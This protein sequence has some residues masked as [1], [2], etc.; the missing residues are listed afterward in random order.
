MLVMLGLYSGV[1]ALLLHSLVDFNFANPSLAS[2][3]F[4]TAGLFVSYGWS[5]APVWASLMKRGLVAVG[6]LLV[7]AGAGGAAMQLGWADRVA[8]VNGLTQRLQASQV[9]LDLA[10][11]GPRAAA[12]SPVTVST[13]ALILPEMDDVNELGTVYTRVG[14]GMRPVPR[15]EPLDPDQMLVVNRPDATRELV[16]QGIRAQIARLERADQIYGHNPVVAEGLYLWHLKLLEQ[17]R[18]RQQ[19]RRLSGEVLEWAR[20]TMERSPEQAQ[21][22]QALAEALWRRGNTERGPQAS[23]YFAEGMTHWRKAVAL[24]PSSWQTWRDFG[25]ALANYGTSMVVAARRFDR[26]RDEEDGWDYVNEAMKA[27]QEARRLRPDNDWRALLDMGTV[28]VEFGEELWTLQRWRDSAM[29]RIRGRWD[30]IMA[31]NI[32]PTRPEAWQEMGRAIEGIGR[33]IQTLEITERAGIYLEE[34]RLIQLEAAALARFLGERE[35]N[36]TGA[37]P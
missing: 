29:L 4:A 5:A 21:Y 7:A 37:A 12:N 2:F 25:Q 28:M 20:E 6:V 26:P 33:R 18:D 24:N 13:A 35:G 32:M 16:E 11:A 34:G 36:P 27:W 31:R 15:G 22:H 14:Q 10:A 30:W 1:L 8:G 19:Q 23:E 17:A 9:L 3:G